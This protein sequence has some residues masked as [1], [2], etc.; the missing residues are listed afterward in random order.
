MEEYKGNLQGHVEPEAENLLVCRVFKKFTRNTHYENTMYF[1]NLCTKINLTSV[2]NKLFEVTSCD[3]HLLS[4][5]LS[6][7]GFDPSNQILLHRRKHGTSGTSALASPSSQ[8][9]ETSPD[10]SIIKETN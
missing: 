8:G 1:K 7:F 3:I 5:F 9:L 6:M 10:I 2:V 4:L